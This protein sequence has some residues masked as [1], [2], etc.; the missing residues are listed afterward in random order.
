MK[1][2][3]ITTSVLKEHGW[4]ATMIE[5]FL[6]T[7]DAYKQNPCYRSAAPMKLYDPARVKRIERTKVFKET[8]EESA[9]RK[10]SAQKAVET[11]RQKALEYAKTVDITIPVMDFDRL[12]VLACRHYNNLHY[13][14]LHFML[15]DP[16]S[17]D[18]DFL[19]RITVNYLRHECSEYED[20]LVDIYGVIGNHSA[21][22]I[23]K[24]R[25]NEKIFNTYPELKEFF[26]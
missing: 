26:K 15:A 4:T 14:D 9:K 25:V 7:P 22:M 2:K 19:G 16:K 3:Y 24:Q 6:K 11:K 17:S 23:L 8:L 5:R 12:R 20:Y 21:Y 18:P 1:K 13:N 10:Q